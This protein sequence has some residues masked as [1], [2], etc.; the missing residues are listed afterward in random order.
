MSPTPGD[1]AN[2]IMGWVA[3][4]RGV[5]GTVASI[6]AD[7]KRDLEAA[8]RSQLTEARE[9]C[10]CQEHSVLVQLE[11]LVTDVRRE[12]DAARAALAQAEADRDE[13]RR[14]L[15]AIDVKLIVEREHHAE[16]R[17][18]SNHNATLAGEAQRD[19]AR[20]QGE[21][22]EEKRISSL[23]ESA[24]HAAETEIATARASLVAESRR[25]AR[26][27][28]LLASVLPFAGVSDDSLTVGQHRAAE[29]AIDE[30]RA[31]LATPAE[32]ATT[33]TGK[34]F[35]QVL[36][37]ATEALDIVGTGKLRPAPIVTEGPRSYAAEAAPTTEPEKESP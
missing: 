31:F 10:A 22:D 23:R 14:T 6:L 19:V 15:A 32:T 34:A 36:A 16:T 9:R 18:T 33:P 5:R 17:R 12:R 29:K 13:A 21:L 3:T 8:L 2:E 11:N 24:W 37:E 1:V 7:W 26:A 27:V 35:D 28:A 25:S 4:G 30:A 20:L